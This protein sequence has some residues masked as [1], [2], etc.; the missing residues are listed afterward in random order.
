MSKKKL[1][2]LALVV[3]MIAILSFGTLA[4]FSDS[5]KVKNDFMIAGSDD[6]TPDE[7]FSVGV[8]EDKN[9]DG[10]PDDEVDGDDKGLIYK[11]ILPGDVLKKEV[12]IENTGY[13]DQ[14]IRVT[15]TV[16]NAEAWKT[17]L[18]KTGNQ[19]PELWEIVNGLDM[20]DTWYSVDAPK[21][22]DGNIIYTLYYRNILLGDIVNANDNV[23][24]NADVVPL[25]TAVKIPAS[26]TVTQAAAFE[27]NFN[28]TVKAEAVQ[29]ENLGIDTSS[30]YA[31]DKAF[32][33][34]EADQPIG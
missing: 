5:D 28:I 18:G 10:Q 14:Y 25:F 15:V 1:L 19:I 20:A 4:W 8:W 23:S 31:A 27:N 3:I 30:G 33:K 22:A 26:M 21:V 7:I 13:Y 2:S 12:K 9:G 24:F 16:S 29:T 17:V 32:A 34:V 11:D 6:D